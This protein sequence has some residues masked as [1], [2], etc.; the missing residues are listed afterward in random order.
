MSAHRDEHLELCAAQVLGVLDEPGRAELAEHLAGGCAVC[1]AELVQLAEG[2]LVLAHA[3]PRVA[4]PPAARARVLEAVRAAGPVSPAPAPVP[5]PERLLAPRG[6]T[7]LPRRGPGFVTLAWAAAA[8]LIAATALV[9][10]QRN[11]NL[12]R[13]LTQ[14]M[15]QNHDLQRSLAKEREWSA[16]LEAPGTQVVSLMPTPA[17]QAVLQARV[18]FD[19]RS[20]RAIVIADALHAPT[21]HDYQLWA[22]TASGPTSLGLL[23]PDANGRAVVKLENVGGNEAVAAFAFSLEVTGG[24]PD[25]HKPSGPV[26]LVGKLA[27]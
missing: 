23:K 8:V 19:P 25:P 2:A 11:A 16:L 9:L 26:V 10:W 13:A 5:L 1:E 27:G 18:V 17:G 6:V 4:A 15:A 24:S 20:K 7:P 14:A 12:S 22:I 3:A 21:G